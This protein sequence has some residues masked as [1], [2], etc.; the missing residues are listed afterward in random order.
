M[1]NLIGICIGVGIWSVMLCLAPVQSRADAAVEARSATHLSVGPKDQPQY[2]VHS[3]NLT[4][5]F[6]ADGKI[7]GMALGPQSTVL[8]VRGDTHLGGCQTEGPVTVRRLAGDG[9][10]FT[11]KVSKDA[12]RRCT[13]VERF[14]P[15]TNSVRW[16]VQ[17]HSYGEDWSAPIDTTLKWPTTKNILTW[18]AWQDP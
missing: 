5:E 8:A 17:I 3:P 12:Q 9:L 16:G 1:L 2:E 10:E 4:F 6:S 7:I 11:R 15:T 13:V 18:A 14:V